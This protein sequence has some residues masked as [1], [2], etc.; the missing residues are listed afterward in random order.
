MVSALPEPV[1]WNTTALAGA[2]GKGS[3][4]VSGG[5]GVRDGASRSRHSLGT[6][7]GAGAGDSLHEASVRAVRAAASRGRRTGMITPGEHVVGSPVCQ[8]PFGAV[9]RAAATLDSSAVTPTFTVMLIEYPD[10]TWSIEPVCV[11]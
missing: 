8:E 5:A 1:T 9:T 11:K 7:A 6:V 3:T 4:R 10:Q 2:V